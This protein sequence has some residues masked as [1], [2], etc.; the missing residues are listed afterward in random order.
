MSRSPTLRER[1][2]NTQ[3][4]PENDPEEELT[5]FIHSIYHYGLGF[6]TLT[7]LVWVFISAASI[8][9]S[10]LLPVPPYALVIVIFIIMV[11]LNCIPKAAY[12]TPCNWILAAVVLLCTIVAGGCLVY[13]FTLLTVVLM[14]VLTT[15]LV[16][17]L[18]FSGAKCPQ[19][20][21]P[22][23]VCSTCLMIILLVFLIVVG[24]VQLFTSSRFA[25]HAFMI[26][27]FVMLIV[28][29]P[30]QAQFNHGRMTIVEV[31]PKHH[32]I[33]CILTLYLHSIIFFCCLCYLTTIGDAEEENYTP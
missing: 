15:V 9:M 27:L 4:V 23:G 19:E 5:T 10:K 26:T 6:I 24:I 30:I 29:I 2:D 3:T 12:C 1:D 17:I 32:L 14:V 31:V 8:N 25:L 16:L 11:V 13:S 33:I 18:N 28:A 20:L 21:L 22:G 7:V